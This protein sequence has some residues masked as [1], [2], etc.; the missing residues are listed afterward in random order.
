M[1]G[2][3]RK[4]NVPMMVVVM[5]SVLGGDHLIVTSRVLWVKLRFVQ[6]KLNPYFD[7]ML[8]QLSNQAL[9]NTGGGE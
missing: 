7:M 8:Y 1:V 4:G 6:W 5:L 3:Y 9:V 2:R